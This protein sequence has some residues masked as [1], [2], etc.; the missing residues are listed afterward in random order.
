MPFLIPAAGAAA[1]GTSAATAAAVSAAGVGVAGG[2]ATA[3]TIGAVAAP[4]ASGFSLASLA[5]YAT[6]GAGALGALSAIQQGATANAQGK[7]Q[8]RLLQQQAERER[9]IGLQDEEAFRKAQSR[10][11]A[12]RRAILGGSG[13]EAGTGSPLLTAEDMTGEIELQALKIRN[14]SEATESRLLADASMA[15]WAG[16]QARKQS[17]VRGGASLLQGA[18]YSFGKSK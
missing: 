11:M 9:Q 6:I 2:S 3:A 13:V 5:S 17:F 15:K 7:A 12:S 18:G 8:A 10:V 1:A 4:A 14:N 16:G